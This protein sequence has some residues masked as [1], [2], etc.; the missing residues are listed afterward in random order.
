VSRLP[1]YF[2]FIMITASHSVFSFCSICY[3]K[4]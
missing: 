2:G 3:V 1:H 4:M